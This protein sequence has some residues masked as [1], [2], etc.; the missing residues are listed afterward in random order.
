M[1]LNIKFTS[2]PGFIENSKGFKFV[3]ETLQYAAME[4]KRFRALL[5]I[6]L[7]V[8]DFEDERLMQQ[9]VQG[10]E[11]PDMPAQESLLTGSV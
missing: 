3:D 11:A 8:R 6:L 9:L 7:K 1:G 10:T 2:R 5:D 4:E